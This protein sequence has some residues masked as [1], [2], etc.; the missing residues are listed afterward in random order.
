MVSY[1][2]ATRTIS[3][4]T[5]SART[6]SPNSRRTISAKTLSRE[7]TRRSRRPARNL[8]KRMKKLMGK[9]RKIRII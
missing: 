9:S 7:K 1:H 4:R 5:I 3:A 8:L 2:S 6:R